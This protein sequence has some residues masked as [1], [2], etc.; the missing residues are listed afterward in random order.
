MRQDAKHWYLA[1]KKRAGKTPP[2]SRLK[3]TINKRMRQAVRIEYLSRSGRKLRTQT[4]TGWSCAKGND[5][6]TPK[7]IRIVDHRR[8]NHT[9]DL[10]EI[11]MEHNKGISARK[12]TL[13]YLAR[14]S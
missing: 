2:F 14:G 4:F 7:R 10:Y 5:Q 6:C 3:M 8:G 9:T 12:F 11:R 1:A 13:R